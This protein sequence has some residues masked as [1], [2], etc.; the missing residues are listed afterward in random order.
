MHTHRQHKYVTNVTWLLISSLSGKHS[1]RS[2]RRGIRRITSKHWWQYSHH[3]WRSRK[4]VDEDRKCYAKQI[5]EAGTYRICDRRLRRCCLSESGFWWA[6]RY[7]RYENTHFRAGNSIK[8]PT[9]SN[10]NRG[11]LGRMKWVRVTN[12]R[13]VPLKG[14]G[15][16]GILLMKM[17]FTAFWSQVNVL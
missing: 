12:R 3:R 11:W 8:E 5:K 13:G 14:V 17:G 4:Q 6:S 10:L 15:S 16:G 2:K 7:M 1:R 9:T